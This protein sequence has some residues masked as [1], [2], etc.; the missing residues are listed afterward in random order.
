MQNVQFVWISLTHWGRVTY[1]CFGNLIIIDSDYG[2]FAWRQSII[3]TNAGILLTGPLGTNVSEIVIEIDTFHKEMHLKLSSSKWQPFFL[4]L[5]EH[6]LAVFL[7]VLTFFASVI[8]WRRTKDPPAPAINEQSTKQKP[9]WSIMRQG[10]KRRRVTRLGYCRYDGTHLPWHNRAA[11]YM[12][13]YKPALYNFTNCS[14]K[15]QLTM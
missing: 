14:F 1:I 6:T 13:Y 11:W 10:N 9:I 8:S 15:Y 12:G 4:G 3:S 5:N 2:L 7:L